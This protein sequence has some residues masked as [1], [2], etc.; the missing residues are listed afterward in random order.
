MGMDFYLIGFKRKD[1]EGVWQD[2]ECPS[3]MRV[4]MGRRTLYGYL[5]D[6]VIYVVSPQLSDDDNECE[7][8]VA[9]RYDLLQRIR[10]NDTGYFNE[11][12]LHSHLGLMMNVLEVMQDEFEV[13]SNELCCVFRCSW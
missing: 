7:G 10:D 6:S 11:R 1:S 8:H 3:Y 13:K 2:V 4:H 5:Q 9:M 12:M